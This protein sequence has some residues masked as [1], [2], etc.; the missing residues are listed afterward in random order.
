MAAGRRAADPRRAGGPDG[1]A[2]QR[3]IRGAGAVG[4]RAGDEVLRGGWA[5]DCPAAG[6]CAILRP[7]RPSRLE[8]DDQT[9]THDAFALDYTAATFTGQRR[10]VSTGLMYYGARFYDPALGRFIQA[11]TI[12]AEPGNPQALNRYS[13]VLGNPLRYTDPTGM[14]S[15]DEIMKYLGVEKWENV[16]AMFEDNGQFAGMWGILGLLRD[17]NLGDRIT[18]YEACPSAGCAKPAKGILREHDGQ[19]VLEGNETW[20]FASLVKS[21][22]VYLV[23]RRANYLNEGGY[24]VFERNHRYNGLRF[25]RDI[26]WVGVGFDIGGVAADAVSFGAAGR[27]VNAVQVANNAR[28]IGQALDVT[29][30]AYNLGAGA[31]E[32]YQEGHISGETAR[33]VGY[34]AA[35]FIPGLGTLS[36]A[37][38]AIDGIFY[39]GP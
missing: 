2:R 7:Y 21:T 38:S 31:V 28:K 13:Y 10:E 15:E 24:R 36:D 20:D 19:L 29:G 14:F 30:A 5:A 4:R 8:P 18:A 3:R 22:N 33:S 37:V 25:K 32:W 35:G 12:V 9:A 17:A 6:Q 11:D 23:H 1:R 26:D 27:V 16:L 34:S 39:W